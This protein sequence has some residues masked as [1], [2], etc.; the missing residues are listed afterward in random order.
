[1]NY[2][3]LLVQQAARLGGKLFLQIDNHAYTYAG[4]LAATDTLA[5]ALPEL[6]G[7]VL[8][9]GAGLWQQAVLFFALQKKGC[10]PVLLH[11]ELS[12]DDCLHLAAQYQLQGLVTWHDKLRCQTFPYT[13][14]HPSTDDCLGVLSSG[15]TGLPKVLY[16]TWAS[17]ADFFPVQN[18]IFHI[19]RETR[20]FLQGNLSFTGNL[21]VWLSI[22]YAGA[23]LIACDTLY[24]RTW[25]R[26]MQEYDVT[27][28]YLVPTKLQLLSRVLTAPLPLVRCIFTGSQ[29]LSQSLY[30]TLH[31]YFPQAEIIAY[32]G[33]TELNYITYRIYDGSATDPQNMGKPFPGVSLFVK[34]G[35][36]YVNSPYHVSGISVPYTLEDTGC[37]TEKGDLFFTGRK[38]SWIN[39]GGYKLSCL[40]LERKLK[41]LPTIREAV[42]LPLSDRL[43]GQNWAACIVTTAA[44]S[45]AAVRQAIHHLLSVKEQPAAILFLDALPLNDRGKIDHNALTGFVQKSLT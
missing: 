35:C 2:Y 12:H 22:L 19:G 25:V 27:A 37:L 43:R 39:K 14:A 28:M 34:D 3:D 38:Q 9:S 29:L 17:W 40:Y 32:Y 42:A 8:I 41:T 10:R 23:T 7:T 15:S 5:A 26:L 24:S 44:A 45:Q 20:L 21:N 30:R 31:H 1:M 18:E 11:H 36:I 6:S 33:A 4:T 13:E 16:R